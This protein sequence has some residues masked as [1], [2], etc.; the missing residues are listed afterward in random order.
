MEEQAAVIQVDGTYGGKAVVHHKVFGVDE[1]GGVF[2]NLDSGLQQRGIVGPGNL[3]NIP[4]VRDVGGDDAHIHPGL[5]GVA[6]GG[7][8]GHVDDQVGCGDIDIVLGLGNHIQVD[9]L[10]HRLPV[11]GSVSVRL[12]VTRPG[13]H[14]GGRGMEVLKILV[15]VGNIVPH[16]EEHNR[17]GP[18]GVPLQQN[19]AVL[20]VAEPLP[21]IDVLVSQV[22]TSGKANLSVDNEQLTV[23]PV[24]Q[25]Q[26][27]HR[28]Q[29]VK[30]PTLNA[31]FGQ[32]FVVITGK[33]EHAAKI[34]VQ[35][36]DL[37]SL[38]GFPFQDGQDAVP[39]DT[40]LNDKILQKD[41]FFRPFQLLQHPGKGVVTQRK[42]L[43][44]RVCVGGT[45]GPALQIAG[46][47]G[48]V[49]PQREEVLGFEILL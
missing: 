2:I 41:I 33:G 10:S 5:G 17:H 49:A 32:N 22:D 8:G 35:H 30:H 1:A 18:D 37:H 28:H 39:K 4:L 45:G 25:P 31:L 6:Q 14:R 20:P 43:S 15:P 21:Y 24:V 42:I 12:D 34:V 38:S 11:Q 27:H 48:G 40:G 23:V 9:R 26:G 13:P 36:P 47:S 16:G 29:P 46:L 7:V 3:K 44:L 19:G